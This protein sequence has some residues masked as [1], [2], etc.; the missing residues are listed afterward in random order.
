MFDVYQGG[1]AGFSGQYAGYINNIG[2]V[3][4]GGNNGNGGTYV[5]YVDLRNGIVYQGGIVGN[6]GHDIGYVDDRFNTIHMGGILGNGGREIGRLKRNGMIYKNEHYV[7]YVTNTT[8]PCVIG[9]AL[10]LIFG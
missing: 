2:I 8:N 9:A 3:Y 5:G 1:T 4:K 7:G 10:L 6:G